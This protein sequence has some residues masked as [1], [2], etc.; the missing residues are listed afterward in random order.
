MEVSFLRSEFE[1]Q[2]DSL[3]LHYESKQLFYCMMQ[4][5]LNFE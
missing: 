1:L 3:M 2:V 4:E 5:D